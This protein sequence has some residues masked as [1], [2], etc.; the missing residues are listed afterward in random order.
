M[1]Y[2]TI[3]FVCSNFFEQHLLMFTSLVHS[4]LNHYSLLLDWPLTKFCE[5]FYP[6]IS[7][8]LF[9]LPPSLLQYVFWSSSDV[10]LVTALYLPWPDKNCCL[11]LSR[12]F[13]CQN[14]PKTK[15]PAMPNGPNSP[16]TNLKKT[17]G[18]FN[19][20]TRSLDS[21]WAFQ[22]KLVGKNSRQDERKYNFP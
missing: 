13:A 5:K 20:T 21:F 7:L 22:C 17:F 1:W 19:F 18:I 16:K 15:Q 8:F 6:Q 4:N 10:G 3:F 2:F 12:S 9:I 11:K 14:V